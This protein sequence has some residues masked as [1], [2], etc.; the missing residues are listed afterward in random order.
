MKWCGE[1]I[2]IKFAKIFFLF[3]FPFAFCWNRIENPWK[4][5]MLDRWKVVGI[6]L[7][8]FGGFESISGR[9]LID[10]SG[11]YFTNST[12]EAR[13]SP[14]IATK[15]IVVHPGANLTIQEGVEIRF[16]PGVGIKIRGILHTSV[17]RKLFHQTNFLLLMNIFISIQTWAL[18]FNF[19]N[20]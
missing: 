16:D 11:S 9:D 5:S 19:K 10:V 15:D 7:V 6:I 14:Y 4:N 1:N 2:R 20:L 13:N 17:K 8:V 12:I 3:Y 18:H